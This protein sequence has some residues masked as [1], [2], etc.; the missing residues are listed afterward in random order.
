MRK[1]LVTT[2]GLAWLALGGVA[3]AAPMITL[4]PGPADPQYFASL[5]AGESDFTLGDVTWSLVSGSASTEKGSVAGQYA[6]PW[7]MGDTTYMSV[8]KG[9]TEQATW[10]TPQ[11]RLS[12]Y[13]GS[14]DAMN[15]DGI[16]NQVSITIDGYTLTGSDLVTLG[17][18]GNGSQSGPANNE[19][20]T[21][22]GLSPFTTVDFHDAGKNA[23]EFSLG[24]GVPEPSTWAMMAIGFAGLGYAGFRRNSKVRAV[25]V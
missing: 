13:W 14:I 16:L 1:T 20:V 3:S 10:A 24:S 7:G 22:T 18:I 21:I 25:A 19:W 11:T 2:T 8:Q 6:A 9:G 17:A 5:A 12:I 4:S 15:V 23:F